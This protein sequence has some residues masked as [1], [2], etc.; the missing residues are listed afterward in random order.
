VDAVDNEFVMQMRAGG[1][2]GGT[3]VTD[4]LSLLHT[5]AFFHCAFGEVQVFR[6][7]AVGVLDEHVVSVGAGIGGLDH[8]AV[9]G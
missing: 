7:D 4:G 8:R 1:Q 9:T 3:D 6:L 5:L 2:A